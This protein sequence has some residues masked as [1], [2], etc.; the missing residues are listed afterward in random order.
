MMLRGNRNKFT[1][2]TESNFPQIGI[3]NS[4]LRTAKEFKKLYKII[5]ILCI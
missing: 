5:H 3:L 1:H 2:I 4:N